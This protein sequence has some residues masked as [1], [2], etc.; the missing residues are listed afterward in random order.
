MQQ[1]ALYSVTGI[2]KCS[3]ATVFSN[4]SDVKHTLPCQLFYKQCSKTFK[5]NRTEFYNTCI[6]NVWFSNAITSVK[7]YQRSSISNDEKSHYILKMV[8]TLFHIPS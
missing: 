4:G 1:T 7:L 3:S 2:T 8:L 6:E 5:W